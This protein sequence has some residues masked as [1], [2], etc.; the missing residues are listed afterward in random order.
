MF[1][2][3]QIAPRP[4]QANWVSRER[5]SNHT[6][7]FCQCCSRRVPCAYTRYRRTIAASKCLSNP[8]A[9]FAE[10]CKREATYEITARQALYGG[11][12]PHVRSRVAKN[13]SA[14]TLI[15]PLSPSALPKF[16]RKDKHGLALALDHCCRAVVSVQ[17]LACPLRRDAGH[18]CCAKKNVRPTRYPN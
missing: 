15:R 4:L 18:G 5:R 2:P 12:E 3:Q 13:T 17:D 11:S 8:R 16:A 1:S 9:V 7:V 6:E 10:K 14:R